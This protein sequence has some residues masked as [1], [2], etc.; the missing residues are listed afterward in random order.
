MST[1]CTR[2]TFLHYIGALSASALLFPLSGCN[3]SSPI[4]IAAHPWPGYEF[5]FLARDLGWV[6]KELVSFKE[7][8]SATETIELLAKGEVDAGALT[9]DEVIRARESGIALSVVL[10]FDISAGADIILAK[11]G[12]KKLSQIKAK[13]IG[14]DLD[15]VGAIMLDQLLKKAGLSKTDINIVELSVDKQ[16]QA[17]ESDHID[18]A[19]TY[20]P[21]ATQLRALGAVELFSSREA[22]EL[23]FDV[24]AVRED[25]LNHIDAITHIINAHFKAQNHFYNNKEDAIYRLADGLGIPSKQVPNL[26]HGLILPSYN[27]NMRLLSGHNPRII[28]ATRKLISVMQE[29]EHL[30]QSISTKHL[31]NSS[32]LQHLYHE[33]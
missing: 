3:S 17:W 14:V 1:D 27:N 2:Q 10:L 16:L 4:S 15:V 9:L 26:Y 33:N 5:M 7:S 30:V 6:N 25:S 24:L 32:F 13:R 19:I 11:P 23:I 12:I 20:E 28:S 21:I 18:I 22:P 8:L 31:F 29:S